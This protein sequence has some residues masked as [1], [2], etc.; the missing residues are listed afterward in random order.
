MSL[1]NRLINSDFVL[2]NSPNAPVSF[3]SFTSGTAQQI[4]NSWFWQNQG[5]G[6]LT[7][8]SFTV[9]QQAIPIPEIYNLP[10]GEA[11]TAVL[12]NCSNL[13]TPSST[14]TNGATPAAVGATSI[15]TTANANAAVGQYITGTGIPAGTTITAVNGD[16]VT[17]TISQALT[18]I[19]AA[20]ATL[21][22]SGYS[23]FYQTLSPKILQ[24]RYATFSFWAN[25]DTLGNNLVVQARRNYG[26]GTS[27]TLS[28]GAT[29]NLSKNITVTNSTIAQ[30][31][32]GITGTG[33]PASTTI[34]SINSL[35]SITLSAAATASNTGLTFTLSR[36]ISADRIFTQNAIPLSG[37]IGFFQ[38][39]SVN[40]PLS[41]MYQPGVVQDVTGFNNDA[42]VYIEMF[43][44]AGVGTFST[45]STINANSVVGNIMIAQPQLEAKGANSPVLWSNDMDPSI[46]EGVVNSQK[47]EGVTTVTTT[48]ATMASNTTYFANNAALV[49]LT[50]PATANV[51]DEITVIGQGAGGWKIAQLAGQ[52]IYMNATATTT[53]TGGNL[54]SASANSSCQLRCMV[55]NTTWA[56]I[57]ASQL[58]TVT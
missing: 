19:V 27:G 12:F 13:G 45:A 5:G 52:K 31:G 14:L 8:P 33:I 11:V 30:V 3:S 23:K 51:N 58:P 49:T 50:L 2:T 35:T 16:N 37:P 24:G 36:T 1:T 38:R 21:T 55:A 7:A 44:Q 41:L 56:L 40:F 20:G 9:S 32:D 48:S 18:A 10:S 43:F 53:G 4:L 46:L 25:A 26:T 42:K 15:V 47:N 17:I 54:A 57:N 6:G 22:V 34:V 39:Y 28:G 29:T